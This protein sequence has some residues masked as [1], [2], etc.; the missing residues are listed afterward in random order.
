MKPNEDR[1]MTSEKPWD[2]SV[3]DELQK[4]KA[5]PNWSEKTGPFFHL[6]IPNEA[7]IGP[8]HGVELKGFFEQTE[9]P[10]GTCVRDAKAIGDWHDIH[11]HAFFQRRK[12]QIVGSQDMP[13]Q[14]EVAYVLIEG[15]KQGPYDLSELNALIE[16]KELL[17]TDQVS[18]DEGAN[19][20][21]LYE[22]DQFDRRNHQQ[23]SLPESPGWDV[24]KDSNT[25]IVDELQNPN[26]QRI[27]ED[28]IAG[29]A[30]LENLKSGKT[31]KAY[32]RIAHSKG[33]EQ[34]E[35]ENEEQV[36]SV[37]PLFKEEK[38][39]KKETSSESAKSKIKYAYAAGVLF[40]LMGSFYFLT[41]TPKRPQRSMSSTSS[42][43]ARELKPVV[44]TNNQARKGNRNS[45]RS[46]RLKPKL[47]PRTRRPASITTSDSFRRDERQM[48]D[49]P[50]KEDDYYADQQEEY[51]ADDYAYDRGETPVE[52]DPVRSK[53][54]K[55]TIDSTE[56]FYD[57]QQQEQY[58][59]EYEAPYEDA[60]Q[61]EPAEVWSE[62]V[63]R[64]PAAKDEA[65]YNED[66]LYEEEAY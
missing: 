17:L 41:A 64:E 30:F 45:Y 60:P 39:P 44:E 29:L 9:L 46:P 57:E 2:V 65:L 28:A 35:Y 11:S 24:F 27:E 42:Q 48:D 43:E 32:D 63:E 31:A 15:Q 1:I 22:Y 4:M 54:D 52:Q 8:F 5:A 53:L 36:A 10:Q 62:E 25:E 61:I 37:E 56:N 18:F 7:P 50:Y 58:Q 14:S 26:E 19:W 47:N 38:H 23:S 66:A 13:E 21:K 49:S 34:E 33:S 55:K 16:E 20:R 51:Y 40:M 12:P 6:Q 3:L 59:A